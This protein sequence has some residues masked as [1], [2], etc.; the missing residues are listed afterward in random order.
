MIG[1]LDHGLSLAEAGRIYTLL[2]IGDGLVAQIPALLSSTAVAVIV[3]R[4]SRASTLSEQVVK[5]LVQHP[6]ALTIA[7]GVLGIIGLVARNAERRIPAARGRHGR[8]RLLAREARAGRRRR[9]RRSPTPRR[10]A[11]RRPRSASSAGTT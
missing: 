1:T 8:R 9:P 5:Q 7:G 11:K 6:R 3:T 4:M 10:S 2:T